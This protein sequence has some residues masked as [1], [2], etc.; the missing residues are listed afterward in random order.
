MDFESAWFRTSRRDSWV[1]KIHGGKSGYRFVNVSIIFP[2][3]HQKCYTYPPRRVSLG[4]NTRKRG[5]ERG[6]ERAS[7]SESRYK[8]REIWWDKVCCFPGVFYDRKGDPSFDI[9][10]YYSE[11]P[12]FVFVGFIS[13]HRLPFKWPRCC[14]SG[15]V[16]RFVGCQARQGSTG[17]RLIR[18]SRPHCH[19]GFRSA[20]LQRRPHSPDRGQS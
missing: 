2:C 17:R 1:V 8:L 20:Q 15:G 9:L 5:Q 14:R 4:D 13:C 10:L 19:P 6:G 12:F 16:I 3:T 11:I 7:Y 18:T